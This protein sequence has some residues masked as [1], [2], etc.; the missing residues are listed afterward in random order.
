MDSATDRLSNQQIILRGSIMVAL[1]ILVG[2]LAHTFGFRGQGQVVAISIFVLIISA[3]LFFWHFRLSHRELVFVLLAV[4]LVLWAVLAFGLIWPGRELIRWTSFTLLLV[5]LTLATSL[6]VHRFLD[7]PVAV[8]V[9]QEVAA[10]TAPD[11]TS[12]IR[13]KLH[14]GTELRVQD[15]RQ[16]WVR[17][18][19]P[20]GQQ[21]WVGEE[22]VELVYR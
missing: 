7:R 9:P 3:T 14:A 2:Y 8:I 22:W 19:L 10:H 5:L 4:N 12:V 18:S 17:V 15:E 11:E 21:G 20:D 13:F 1:S 6:F 16:G